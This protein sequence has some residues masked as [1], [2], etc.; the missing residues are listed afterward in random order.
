MWYDI[1]VRTLAQPPSLPAPYVAFRTFLSTLEGF[2]AGLPNRI[3]RSVWP[4]LSGA[5][6]GQLLAA[7]RF[8]ALVDEQGAPTPLL[9]EL[10]A[11]GPEARQ[12]LLRRV[13]EKSYPDLIALE[14]A[15]ASPRQLEEAVRRGGY[16]GATLRK[17]ASFFLQAAVYA[18]LPISVLLRKKTRRGEL[19]R[20][21]PRHAPARPTAAAAESRILRLRS[22][23]TLT[24]SM[25]V[26]FLELSREDREFVFRLLDEMKA[27][28]QEGGPGPKAAESRVPG[29]TP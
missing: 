28:E 18:D 7:F 14:L 17:A 27:Y 9:R 11:A 5:V 24:L 22:G 20:A 21:A 2:Q 26:K 1:A 23:G 13:L 3:D 15:R 4:S 8:L 16:S 29:L 19:R 25:D 12:R 6:Q 10:A